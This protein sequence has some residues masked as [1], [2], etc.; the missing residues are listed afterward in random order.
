MPTGEASMHSLHQ[1][2]TMKTTRSD[3]VVGRVSPRAAL[4]NSKHPTGANR[5]YRGQLLRCLR[6]LLF[7]LL[8]IIL[9]IAAAAQTL[10]LEIRQDAT[11]YNLGS[12]N[13]MPISSTPGTPPGS[14]GRGPTV[15]QQQAAGLTT[16]PATTNQL[17]SFIDFGALAVP[18]VDRRIN[19]NAGLSYTA[20][21]EN[22]DLPRAKVN[23]Q[24]LVIMPTARVGAPFLSRSL[25]F[26]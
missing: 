9:P 12:T 7:N 14:D 16:V 11:R 23:N 2:T 3:H 20:N 13:G 22:L 8:L 26:L 1:K 21:A 18:P 25:S 17:R 4:W 5:E 15:A 10:P 6:S 19:L 24:I